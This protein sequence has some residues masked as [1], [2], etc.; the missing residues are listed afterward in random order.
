MTTRIKKGGLSKFSRKRRFSVEA[1]CLIMYKIPLLAQDEKIAKEARSMSFF[2]V[3]TVAKKKKIDIPIDSYD[4]IAQQSLLEQF[5][6]LK[7]LEVGD[8]SDEESLAVWLASLEKILG[9]R[10]HIK[11]VNW[12]LVCRYRPK[13]TLFL[14]KI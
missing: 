9:K 13:V 10:P 6:K 7:G 1:V 4:S 11:I 8:I 12:E 2:M 14:S 5:E 3:D